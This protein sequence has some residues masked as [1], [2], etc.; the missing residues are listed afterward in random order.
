M[1]IKQKIVRQFTVV[2]PTVTES[3]GTL[4]YTW[5]YGTFIVE[6]QTAKR[7]S[8]TENGPILTTIKVYNPENRGCAVTYFDA[9][10]YDGQCFLTDQDCVHLVCGIKE[11]VESTL[12]TLHRRLLTK[13]NQLVDALELIDPK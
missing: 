5:D 12:R 9:S 4:L 3:Y 13:V 6:A 10:D 8:V 7:I 2:V 1:A 11:K